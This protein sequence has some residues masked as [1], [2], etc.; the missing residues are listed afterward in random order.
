MYVSSRWT[1]HLVFACSLLTQRSPTTT[2][3]K[4]HLH[5]LKQRIGHGNQNSLPC[6]LLPPLKIPF[7]ATNFWVK[8]WQNMKTR[9]CNLAINH[10]VG[11]W[12]TRWLVTAWRLESPRLRDQPESS[13]YVCQVELLLRPKTLNK[14][15]PYLL[16]L[17]SSQTTQCFLISLACR[18]DAVQWTML[19]RK[20][21]NPTATRF[22][23]KQPKLAAFAFFHSKLFLSPITWCALSRC[24]HGGGN[25][26][27]LN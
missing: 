9:H 3:G 5:S 26:S 12:S 20:I 10:T 8:R 24:P 21:K 16:L 27:T 25:L 23:I 17:R 15:T 2:D 1:L 18:V 22:L 7:H 6:H 4:R 13:W 19:P 11:F 14:H